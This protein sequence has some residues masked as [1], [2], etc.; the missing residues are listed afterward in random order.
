MA[1][2][3]AKALAVALR[4]APVDQALPLYAKARRWHVW[5]YQMTSAAFTP[6]YQSDGRFLPILRDYAL[7]PLSRI[8]PVPRFLTGLVRGDA[9]RAIRL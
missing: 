5:V 9:L 3:D 7:F 1:L 8:P 2:L 4:I 6:Q